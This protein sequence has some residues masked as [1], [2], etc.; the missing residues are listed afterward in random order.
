VLVREFASVPDLVLAPT[1]AVSQTLQSLALAVR[2]GS[3]GRFA[4]SWLLA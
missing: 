4:L 3:G 1:A 2:C